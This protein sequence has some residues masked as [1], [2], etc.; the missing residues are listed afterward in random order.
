MQTKLGG[1]AL[2]IFQVKWIFVSKARAY[3]QVMATW[4]T[5]LEWAQSLLEILILTKTTSLDVLAAMEKAS[6]FVLDNHFSPG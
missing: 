6:V 3:L 4:G 1:S 2:H 5:P